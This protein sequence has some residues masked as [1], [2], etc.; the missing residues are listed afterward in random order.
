MNKEALKS[1]LYVTVVVSLILFVCMILS[2]A[3]TMPI[4]ASLGAT[5]EQVKEYSNMTFITSFGPLLC[6]FPVGIFV[7]AYLLLNYLSPKKYN[8]QY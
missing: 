4:N 6:L 7:L 8:S 2:D 3:M 5:P 1:S